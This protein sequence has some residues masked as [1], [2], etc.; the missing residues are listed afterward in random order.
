MTLNFGKNSGF[1]SLAFAGAGFFVMFFFFLFV[2]PFVKGS[3]P[4]SDVAPAFVMAGTWLGI[5]VLFGFGLFCGLMGFFEKVF[6]G[7]SFMGVFLNLLFLAVYV[8]GLRIFV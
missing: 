7:F 3:Y 5:F 8:L 2:V 6:K 4:S 1:A